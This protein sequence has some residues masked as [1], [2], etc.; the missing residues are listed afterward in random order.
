[1]PAQASMDPLPRIIDANANRALEALRTLEDLARFAL[2]DGGLCGGLKTARHRLSAALQRLPAD[3]LAANRSTAG[4]V[5]TVNATD[6]EYRRDGLADIARAAGSRLGESLR[7][8]EECLK[9]LDAAA[10]REVEQLRYAAYDLAAT[11]Q[12]RVPGQA[13]QW[14]VCVLVTERLCRLPWQEV[15]RQSVD[16][17]AQAIQV[18]EKDLDDGALAE[19]VSW[20]VAACRP[21]G[22]RVVVN[23]RADIALVAGAD[24]VHVGQAD[25][26]PSRIRQLC[27]R[28]LAIGMSAHD[29]AEAA[30]AVA[31]GADSCGVGAM[32]PTGVKPEVA[33]RGPAW[34]A[35]FVRLHPRL[36][37]LAIGGITPDNVEPLIEV[38]CR[39]VAVSACVCG[40][41]RPAAVVA[42]LVDRF[43]RAGR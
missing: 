9:A 33:A 26:A 10:A 16:G 21:A 35:E 5:G 7:V 28:R 43:A 39:G 41:E 2:D 4:D 8:I 32:Y 14:R 31:E 40:A 1:M 15:V 17:G 24:A 38:G 3:W 27:G 34:L 30:R 23:D 13:E 22:V 18:R 11:V 36:P 25:L 6:S 29:A 20:T 19:R 37:H 42:G 12:R